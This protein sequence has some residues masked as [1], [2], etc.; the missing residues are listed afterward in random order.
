MENMTTQIEKVMAELRTLID[1]VLRRGLPDANSAALATTNKSGQ[2]SV[3]VVYIQSVETSGLVFFAN[4]R[5]GKGL[6]LEQNPQAAVC[7]YWPG[8]QHQVTLEGDVEMLSDADSSAYWSKRPREA[9][10][11][12]W[13]SEQAEPVQDKGQRKAQLSKLKKEF[14]FENA[15]RPVHW[16]AYRIHPTRI[17]FWPSGWGRLRARTL[18]QKRPDGTWTEQMEN[19]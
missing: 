8:L 9:Q 2:P 15:P 5:S 16:R 17:E 1:E 6:Q 18:Y 11:G 13:A 12:A 7:F 14:S 3:R 10:L 19:P 4:S